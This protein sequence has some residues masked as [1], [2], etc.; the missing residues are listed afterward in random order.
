MSMQVNLLI[1][2]FVIYYINIKCSFF[3]QKSIYLYS[4]FFLGTALGDLHGYV[5]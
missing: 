4:I 1:F 3:K 2:S 5:Q